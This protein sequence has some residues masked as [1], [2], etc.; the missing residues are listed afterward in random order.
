[1]RFSNYFLLLIFILFTARAVAFTT[2]YNGV[3]YS[4]S[5]PHNLN[6]F[7]FKA[8]DV[9]APAQHRKRISAMLLWL[10]QYY[11]NQMAAS[12]YGFKT[13]GLFTETLHPD[14][15]RLVQIDGALGLDA[16][17]NGGNQLLLNEVEQF[18]NEH[19]ELMVSRHS[20]VLVGTPGF[21]QMN[22]L[23]Y[24]GTGK[25]C[26]ATD[27]PQLDMQYLGQ[28]GLW[29]D[30]FVTYFGGIAHELGH[31]LNL[32]HSHQ[33]KTENLNP[34]QGTSLMADG[35]YTLT[36]F[37]TFINRAGCAILNRCQVFSA[38]SAGSF[39][40][41]NTSGILSLHTSVQAGKLI[42][43]GRMVSN[44]EVTD[45]NFYQDPFSSPSAGYV[46]IAF[47]V[48]PLGALKD[49]F[50]VEMPAAEVLQ[51]AQV[52][53]PSGPYNLEIEMVLANGETSSS[54]YNYQYTN[55]LPVVSFG[56]GNDNCHPLPEAWTLSDVGYTFRSGSACMDSAGTGIDMRSWADGFVSSN[57]DR[58]TLLH[59]ALNNPDTLECRVLSVSPIWN[60]LGGLMIRSSTDSNA[61]FAAISALDARGVFWQWRSSNGGGS[62][63][64][65][66]TEQSLPMWL[67]LTRS[68]NL[69]KG[70]YSQDGSTWTQYYSKSINLGAA[71]LGGLVTV[72]NGARS[73][74]DHLRHGNLV[75]GVNQEKSDGTIFRVLPNPVRGHAWLEF[76]S[77]NKADCRFVISDAC[78]RALKTENLAAL[79]GRNLIP[80]SLSYLP[81][82]IYFLSLKDDA[83][84]GRQLRLVVE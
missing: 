83:D 80:F 13:F 17:R 31:G 7:Y 61:A 62:S 49:S 76:E 6:V 55:G 66:V 32:P 44:R 33:T 54:G 63:Y 14:S 23:P 59:T 84:G 50:Y 4:S 46:R 43:S 38:D 10:Q 40:D 81:P 53:P 65:L 19:P 29:A 11:G 9:T 72:K 1:M 58:L 8:A 64:H 36:R 74:F 69:V 35:N 16:Y 21:D 27:Y 48:P 51:N 26:F 57:A 60:D 25:T 41:G 15:I 37:P 56:F 34:Q 67:R 52:Y 20:L 30:R 70:F 42:L 79:P 22:G 77:R 18:K 47:S 78:G 3:E 73:R 39:Y 82:G 75:T 24:Y 68:N 28:T 12:G 71:P 2:V 5:R 45:V